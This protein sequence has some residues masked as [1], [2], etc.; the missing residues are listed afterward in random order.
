MFLYIV[1]RPKKGNEMAIFPNVNVSISYRALCTI[2]K[3]YRF[4]IG[5]I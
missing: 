3:C 4:L 2:A 5:N 1:N